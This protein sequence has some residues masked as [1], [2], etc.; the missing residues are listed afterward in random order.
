MLESKLIIFLHLQN[1]C[2]AA[3]AR[4]WPNSQR[5][6]FAPN[7]KNQCGR[8]PSVFLNM[9]WTARAIMGS[10]ISAARRSREEESKPWSRRPSSYN[11][12][13][14][15]HAWAGGGVRSYCFLFSPRHVQKD[16]TSVGLVGVCW[17][18]LL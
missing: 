5:R 10:A 4:G 15:L 16:F 2:V 3:D 12:F 11:F 13:C 17:M 1:L 18:C 14:L 9:T 6:T 8:Q 7:A